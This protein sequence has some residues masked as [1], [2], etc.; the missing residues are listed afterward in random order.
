M[1][2]VTWNVNSVRAREARLLA[3]LAREAPDVLCLQELKVTEEAF[4]FDVIS[5]AGYHAAVYGQRTYNGV[6]ILS[7]TPPEDVARGFD[8]GDDEDPQARLVWATVEGVRVCAAYFPNGQSVGS[9]KWAYKLAWMQR[10]RRALDRLDAA[11][12]FVLAGDFNVAPDERDVAFPEFW[13][14]SVLFHPEARAALEGV[15]AWGLEDA[16][17]RVVGDVQGPYSWWDYRALAFPKGD[18]LRIDHVFATPALAA[19][20]TAARVD[21]DERKG[22]A[23]SDHAPVIVEFG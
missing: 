1:K 4:P 17:R 18:G 16:V 13:R 22:E 15:R 21:R 2:L 20:A 19:R 23:P 6:A 8:D 5:D 7:R 14:G 3:F 12:P 9:D 10:L 11:A